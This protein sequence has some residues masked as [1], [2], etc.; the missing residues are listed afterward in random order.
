MNSVLVNPKTAKE[1]AD[2]LSNPTQA[3]LVYGKK[4]SG[5]DLLALDIAAELLGVDPDRVLK[6]GQLMIVEKSDDKQNITVDNI[7]QLKSTLK[8]SSGSGPKQRRVVLINNAQTMNHEAQNALL[9]SL[10]EP[11]KNTHIVLFSS[12]IANLL[13]TVV[14]RCARINVLP[15]SI[16]QAYQNY[17][18]VEKARVLSAWH[19]SGGAAKLLD[20]L[21]TN[22]DSK[23][24]NNAKQAKDILTSNKY[25]R[26]V[27]LDK[28]SQDKNALISVLD[29][30]D[31][32]IKAIELS[33][34]RSGKISASK[35]MLENRRM[36]LTV[37]SALEN[38]VSVRL[39]ALEAA[40]KLR[41]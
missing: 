36:I 10:E 23:E 29:T 3:V 38:N 25:G 21:I 9:K 20:E 12:S 6:S 41:T 28:L 32:A 19:L 1:I 7:R 33:S 13:P 34:L 8:L 35:K 27:L 15:I 11:P 2:Y 26:I 18:G 31:S 14:S 17:S 22:Y 16:N 30:L 5:A 24:F 37:N 39:A 4:H 40:L